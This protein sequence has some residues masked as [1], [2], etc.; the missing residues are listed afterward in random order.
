MHKGSRWAKIPV[1]GSRPQHT[2]L[3]RGKRSIV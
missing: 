2:T 3:K 1:D